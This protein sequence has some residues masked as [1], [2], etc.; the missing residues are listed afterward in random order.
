MKSV[1]K[2]KKFEGYKYPMLMHNPSPVLGDTYLI[3][4]AISEYEFDIEGIVLYN[5]T[6]STSKYQL[7]YHS[8][9]F[10][11][12]KFEPYEGEITLSN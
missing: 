11:R 7:G 10:C 5:D 8:N 9:I 2:D 1:K 3:I 4:L 6:L 12:H